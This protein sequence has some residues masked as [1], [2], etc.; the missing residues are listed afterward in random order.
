VINYPVPTPETKEEVLENCKRIAKVIDG[1]KTGYPGVDLICFPEYSTQV[2]AHRW[3]LSKSATD[4][5]FNRPMTATCLSCLALARAG[6][7]IA[8]HQLGLVETILIFFWSLV[9]VPKCRPSRC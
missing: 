4:T 5:S 6:P 8:N 3:D 7:S 2:R 1:C 9:C